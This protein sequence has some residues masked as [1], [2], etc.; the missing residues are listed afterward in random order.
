MSIKDLPNSSMPRER[1]IKYGAKSLSDEE[2]LAI[3]LRTGTK[4]N[5]VKQLAQQLLLTYDG[6]K[7]LRYLSI[8]KAIKIKGLGK[9][10]IVTLLASLELG[11]RVYET[12]D[13]E[14]NLK[15]KN[16]EDAFKYFSRIISLDKQENFLVI[17]LDNHKKLITYKVIF[18]GTIN[19]SIV[20]PREVF[21]KA[22]L[23]S[24]SSIILMHNHPSGNVYPSKTD[25]E[26]TS[27]MAKIGEIMGI[28]V[29]DHIIVSEHKY[30]SYVESERLK[31]V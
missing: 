30:Y 18:K 24:A 20:H 23:E 2:L 3:I 10:K 17:L 6:V 13:I 19:E 11:K 27:E 26:I 8:N 29:L 5:N 4:Q 22:F 25:D 14:S 12:F 21:K 16:A 15:V 7:N 31:Y 28:R 9:V 1:L